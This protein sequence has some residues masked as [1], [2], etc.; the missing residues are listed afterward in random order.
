MTDSKKI[1]IVDGT[2]YIF[3]AFF[4][5]KQKLTNQKGFPTNAIFAFK[6]MLA[7]LLKEV[8]PQYVAVVFDSGKPSFRSEIFPEYKA[9]REGI[10][11][12]LVQQIPLIIE[13]VRLLG[14]EPIIIDDFEADDVIATL[15]QQFSD[16]FDVWIIS[17]DKD[18]TQMVSEKVKMYDS[19]R[20]L[21]FSKEEVKKKFGVNPEQI[22]DYLALVGDA[23]DN[24][25]GAKGIGPVGAQKLLS[26]YSN[27]ETLKLN[28]EKIPGKE[29]EKLRLSWAQVEMSKK[30]TQIQSQLPLKI[31][32][33]DLERKTPDLGTL[34]NFYQELNFRPDEFITQMQQ[35]LFAQVSVPTIAQSGEKKK[36]YQ[37]SIKTKSKTIQATSLKIWSTVLP[38]FC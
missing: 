10:A 29:G 38:I 37:R 4:G 24:I 21:L 28:L 16:Q 13:M 14:F 35:E 25:P 17:A 8:Q 27:L 9:H 18:L 36:S 33:K 23:S 31:S 20:G 12:E 1:A 15:A 30:L 7:L 6:N 26:A 2:Y 22:A 3:R 5:I 11:P 34:K 19:M 32:L